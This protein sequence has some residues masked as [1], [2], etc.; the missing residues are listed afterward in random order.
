[1]VHNPDQLLSGKKP[2]DVCP[3]NNPADSFALTLHFPLSYLSPGG[4]TGD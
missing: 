3:E 2:L 4:I 1:M